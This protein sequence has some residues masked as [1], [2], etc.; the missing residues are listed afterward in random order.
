MNIFLQYANIGNFDDSIKYL[1]IFLL[2]TI[3]NH[4][5]LTYDWGKCL[6]FYNLLNL[7]KLRGFQIL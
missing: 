3:V 1:S 2:G 6:H 4:S 7:R 5:R